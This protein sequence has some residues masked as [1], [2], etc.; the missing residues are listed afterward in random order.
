MRRNIFTIIKL[1]LLI[2]YLLIGSLSLFWMMLTTC[3]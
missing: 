1:K 3:D 2:G